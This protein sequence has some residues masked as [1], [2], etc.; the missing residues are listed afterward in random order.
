[1][2]G[3]IAF[4]YASGPQ[5][6]PDFLVFSSG[7]VPSVSEELSPV[8]VPGVS[9]LLLC[10]FLCLSVASSL[11]APDDEQL[12]DGQSIW[13]L[14]KTQQPI[15]QHSPQPHHHYHHPFRSTKR[16]T[17]RFV[18]HPTCSKKILSSLHTTCSFFLLLNFFWA[19][20]FFILDF[21]THFVC[22]LQTAQDAQRFS[23]LNLI[24]FFFP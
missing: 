9:S 23:L 8:R 7:A 16:R 6:F 13:T 11:Y 1:M 3:V 4:L 12:Q 20:W 15:S 19:T 24:R 21:K 10:L 2:T 14:G 17:I 5:V 18:P 22:K